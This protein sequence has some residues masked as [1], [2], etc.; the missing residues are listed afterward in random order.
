MEATR[1]RVFRRFGG[2][3][4]RKRSR[5]SVSPGQSLRVDSHFECSALAPFFSPCLQP[6]HL[7]LLCRR[8][9]QGALKKLS[10]SRLLPARTRLFFTHTPECPPS[11]RAISIA[12]TRLCWFFDSLPPP[13]TPP[14]AGLVPLLAPPASGRPA[15]L[16]VRRRGRA[17][18]LRRGASH[19]NA[20]SEGRHAVTEPAQKAQP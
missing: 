6:R 10:C 1:T 9:Q 20:S 17:A 19:H 18:I 5:K 7:A 11:A 16:R 8:D 14:K 13:P 2:L 15:V 12:N 4:N 3:L